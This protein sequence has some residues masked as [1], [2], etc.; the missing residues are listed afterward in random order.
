MKPYYFL[1]GLAYLPSYILAQDQVVV[2][3]PKDSI[4]T[5]IDTIR[6]LLLQDSTLIVDVRT[7]DEFA[8][9]HILDSV[10]IPINALSGSEEVFPKY[11]N[12]IVVCRTGR[13][14]KEAKSILTAKGLL[15]I[16]DGGNWEIFDRINKT[17]NNADYV[18]QNY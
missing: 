11:V 6:S 18:K 14:S 3:H 8:E 10:N 15:N 17:L 4:I 1:I 13:R 5:G 9:G 2:T 16:T 12:I 7:P